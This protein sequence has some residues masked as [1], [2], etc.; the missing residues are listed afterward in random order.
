[1]SG[2]HTNVQLSILRLTTMNICP[3]LSIVDC[4]RIRSGIY[5]RFPFQEGYLP[6]SNGLCLMTGLRRR[7]YFGPIKDK[8][9]L[10]SYVEE[11]CLPQCTLRSELT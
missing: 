2:I 5:I 7:E 3:K 8:T 6:H 10:I 9:V 11:V 1:M 4:L